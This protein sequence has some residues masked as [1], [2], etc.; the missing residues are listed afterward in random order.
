MM[1]FR[2]EEKMKKI[3]CLL[4][5]A[6]AAALPAA[7]APKPAAKAP[8]STAL[9]TGAEVKELPGAY[10]VKGQPVKLSEF[11][12]KMP[13]VLFFWT[14]HQASVNEIPR[15]VAAAKEFEGKAG[16]IGIGCDDPQRLKN[17]LYLKD[18]NF[19]VLA[20]DR[21]VFVNTFLRR[22][23]RT[24]IAVVIDRDGRLAW[25]GRV[26]G[27]SAVL[28]EM[29]AGKFDLA[30]EIRRE[31]CGTELG[32]ALAVKDYDTALRISADELKRYPDNFEL[33]SLRA[34]I[35]C[36]GAKKPEAA[37][38][39]ID[40]AIRRHPG[41]LPLYELELKVIRAAKLDDKLGGFYR[42]VAADFAEKP[43]VLIK[44]A[45]DELKRPLDESHPEHFCNLIRAAY[46]SKGCRNEQEKAL[47][48]ISYARMC[49]L[50]GRPDLA[51]AAAKEAVTRLGGAN[52][53]LQKELLIYVTY[54]RKLVEISRQL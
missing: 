11:R 9:A 1:F 8:E 37:I 53:E 45:D 46:A 38:A 40:E 54:Y 26:V 48:S 47:V 19:P 16:F 28:K 39:E 31:K 5:V 33:L 29:L 43:M 12:G 27:L 30:E 22:P 52:K 34:G 44:L 15:I 10:W 32:R 42:K 35:F 21:L 13:V 2:G 23:D 41:Q 17:F 14:F 3:F 20:D 49:H 24:P 7:E 51:L 50:L 18:F 36:R 6:L 4:V 25:R